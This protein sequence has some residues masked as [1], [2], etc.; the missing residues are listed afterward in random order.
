MKKILVIAAACG[1]AFPAV[2]AQAGVSSPHDVRTVR[3]EYGDLNLATPQGQKRLNRRV[4]FAARK[5]CGYYGTANASIMES[6]DARACYKQAKAGALT[7][8]AA[9]VEQ[10]AKGG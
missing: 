10:R 3:V 6:V 7:Q 8:F 4:E 9:V 5:V 1:I 2:S